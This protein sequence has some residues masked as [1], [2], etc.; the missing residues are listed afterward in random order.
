MVV[1]LLPFLITRS[2]VVIT[3]GYII[4]CILSLIFYSAVI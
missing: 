4:V 1:E 3:Q 2:T